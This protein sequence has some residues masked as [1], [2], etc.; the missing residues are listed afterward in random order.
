MANNV[1]KKIKITLT[2][3]YLTAFKNIVEMAQSDDPIRGSFLFR[4][5]LA[6]LQAQRNK[7]EEQNLKFSVVCSLIADLMEQGWKAKAFNSE[8]NYLYMAAPSLEL[9]EGENIEEVKGRI[10]AGLT[11][12]SNKQ[13]SSPSVISFISRME[14]PRGHKKRQ[15]SIYNLVDDGAE[16]AELIS[17]MGTDPA[18]IEKGLNDVIK[19]YVQVCEDGVKC[20]K[21]GLHLLDIWRYFRHSWSLEYKPLPGRTMRLL[22][23]N[24]ARPDWPIMGIAMLASPAMN[25]YV[26]DEWIQWRLDDIF[27]GIVS[28]SLKAEI[29]ANTLFL[30]LNSALEK[31][32]TNDLLTEEEIEK[33]SE[34]TLVKLKQVA[35]ASQNNRRTELAVLEGREGTTNE[36][37]IDIRNVKDVENIDWE[38]LSRT[39]LYKKKRAE[40]LAPLLRA[41]WIFKGSNIETEPEIALYTLLSEKRG[42]EA[43][44]VALNEI[45]KAKLASQ[46]AD[47]SVC[48]AVAPYNELLGGKLVTILMGSDD[49]RKIYKDKYDSQVSEIASQLAGRAIKRPTD[50]HV[51]TTTSLYGVGSSQYNRI[52]IPKG[53][54]P[55]IFHDF[56]WKKL[57]LT[58]GY[59]VTHFS[60][61][62][63]SLMRKLSRKYHGAKR[64]NSVFGEGSSPKVRLIREALMIL[65]INDDVVMKHGMSR[66]VYAYE[67]YPNSRG[68][69]SGFAP[70]KKKPRVPS[71]ANLSKAWVKK[72]LVK[73][74]KRKDTIDKLKDMNPRCVSDG[75]KA[76]IN[77]YKMLHEENII[78]EDLA[79]ESEKVATG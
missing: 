64:V 23:R 75:L 24:K 67:Y 55:G 8:D 9:G 29:V 63:V 62:T 26:R 38:K 46:V 76:R 10:R 51:L 32:K 7:D 25:L 78:I 16:L 50:L 73:R 79:P 11:A 14:K 3:S 28:K 45:R 17:K 43:I 71:A 31:I 66:V 30:N 65:G 77:E 44:G 68:D 27:E 74:V 22:I 20:E 60:D 58:T 40:T 72:W 70:S 47:V 13:L 57:K 35:E 42:Q 6:E 59:G 2:N 53:L 5:K 34:A 33:P 49:V 1:D 37:V 61:E 52:K 41:Y 54:V 39:S 18:L 21:T 48:G 19:P 12:I 56:E 15:V 69:L 4:K 36:E